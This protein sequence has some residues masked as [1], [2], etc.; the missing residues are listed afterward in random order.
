MRNAATGLA[1]SLYGLRDYRA[2]EAAARDA[3]ALWPQPRDRSAV[4]ALNALASTPAKA[5]AR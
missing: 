2:A 1:Y 4:S 5:S 3:I